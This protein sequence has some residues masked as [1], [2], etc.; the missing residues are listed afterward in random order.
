MAL[1]STEGYVESASEGDLLSDTGAI[2]LGGLLGLNFI[3][4]TMSGGYVKL[5]QRN[6]ANDADVKSQLIYV[7]PGT[8]MF[9]AIPISVSAGQRMVVKAAQN[10]TAGLQIS[11]FS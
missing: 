11:L 9:G 7:P 10:F 8:T 5:I 6:A 1:W 2:A 4:C 3:G